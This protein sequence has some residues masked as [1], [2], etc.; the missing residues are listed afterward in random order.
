MMAFRRLLTV[1]VEQWQRMDI[2]TALQPR[3][4]MSKML[5]SSSDSGA[6][7]IFLHSAKG[8]SVSMHFDKFP[9]C[10]GRAIIPVHF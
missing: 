4:V 3:T 10:V 2:S 1:A 8:K 5:L 7:A 6:S 9:P